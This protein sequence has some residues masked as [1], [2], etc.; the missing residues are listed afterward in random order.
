MVYGAG[1]KHLAQI[2]FTQEE[3]TMPHIIKEEPQPTK[4]VTGLVYAIP[5]AMV[6]ALQIIVMILLLH[7]HQITDALLILIN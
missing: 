5:G 1:K 7:K 4:L 2:Q 6:R 3:P